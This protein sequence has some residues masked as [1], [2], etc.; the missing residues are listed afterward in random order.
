MGAQF[1]F[2]MW[3]NVLTIETLGARLSIYGKIWD[4]EKLI[5]EIEKRRG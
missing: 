1:L 2:L 3:V 4:L 5:E